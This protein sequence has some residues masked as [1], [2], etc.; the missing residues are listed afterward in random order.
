VARPVAVT[1]VVRETQ[2]GPGEVSIDNGA[3]FR[4]PRQLAE[5]LIFAGSGEPDNEGVVSPRSLVEAEKLFGS[6]RHVIINRI[7]KLRRHLVTNHFN[8]YLLETLSDTSGVT[9]VRFL[10]RRLVVSS[11]PVVSIDS[12]TVG[13]GFRSYSGGRRLSGEASSSGAVRVIEL[14]RQ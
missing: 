9:C 3:P 4:V 5:L 13:A 8:K 7:Y 14:S 11:P 2:Y 10:T 12:E 6:T 1:I